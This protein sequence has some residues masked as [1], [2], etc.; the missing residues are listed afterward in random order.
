LIDHVGVMASDDILH[1]LNGSSDN[2]R[3]LLNEIAQLKKSLAEARTRAAE[4]EEKV[5]R[6]GKA[7]AEAEKD[8][9]GMDSECSELRITIEDQYAE[10]IVLRHE[11]RDAPLD[12][13][14]EKIGDQY[15]RNS[16]LNVQPLKRRASDSL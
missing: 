14:R 12:L 8:L 4:L 3:N 5:E 10:I 7:I 1:Y 11:L 15:T 2:S 13:T 9:L 6:Q 16:I